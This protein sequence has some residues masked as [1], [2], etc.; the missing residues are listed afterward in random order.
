[1]SQVRLSVDADG[2][3]VGDFDDGAEDDA[4]LED[5]SAEHAG[6]LLVDEGADLEGHDEGGVCDR[7][8][9]LLMQNPLVKAKS[10]WLR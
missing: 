2:V 6:V 1:M 5:E 9:A 7:E 3:G 8:G 4:E 10:S